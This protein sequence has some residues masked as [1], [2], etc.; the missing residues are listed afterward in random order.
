MNL[1]NSESLQKAA[2]SLPAHV[3]PLKGLDT[4]GV[5]RIIVSK[6]GPGPI[7]TKQ[8]HSFSA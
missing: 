8:A 3:Q 6:L 4:S 7:V 2:A 5:R 1:V